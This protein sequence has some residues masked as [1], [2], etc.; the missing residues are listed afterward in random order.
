MIAR[1]FAMPYAQRSLQPPPFGQ[2]GFF[3]QLRGIGKEDLAGDCEGFL[4]LESGQQGTPEIP[5]HA[6]V[7]VQ[8][9]HDIVSGRAESGI[10][11]S[12]ESQ[13]E[14]EA[15]ELALAGKYSA[16]N[17]ALPSVEPLSTTMISLP[18]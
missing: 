12:P 8:Q 3:P 2:S 16:T 11:S 14:R 10:R 18:G 7:A 17:A 1:F 6:H 4:I 15:R 9:N 13:I 5:L